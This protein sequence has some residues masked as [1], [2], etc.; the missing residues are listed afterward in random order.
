MTEDCRLELPYFRDANEKIP[1]WDILKKSI[2][3]DLSKVSMPVI[4][5]EPL[6][7]L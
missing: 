5:A 6:T 4:L 1:M 2:G 3:Q 7:S